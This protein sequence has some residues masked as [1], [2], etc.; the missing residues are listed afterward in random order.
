MS[1]S[2]TEKQIA[3]IRAKLAVTAG[4]S[5]ANRLVLGKLLARLL[6]MQGN[7][8][9]EPQAKAEPQDLPQNSPIDKL[10]DNS[11]T[12][13]E[14]SL[15][16]NELTEAENFPYND[17]QRQGIKWAVEGHSFV[18]TGA[19]GTG[20]TTNLRGIV[21]NL[22]ASG[23]CGVIG[24][25]DHKYIHTGAPGIV[26]VSYTNKA[27]GNIKRKLPKYLHN[28]CVTIHKL[29]E[30]QPVFEES[31]NKDTGAVSSTRLFQPARTAYNPLPRSIRILIVDES[32][33]LDVPLWNKLIAAL[34]HRTDPDLQIILMGDIQ[35]L[36]PVFGKSVFIHALQRG[37]P[38]TELTEVYRTALDNPILALAHR[39][40]SGKVIPAPE[41]PKWNIDKSA[42]GLG[43]LTIRPWKKKLTDL[44]AN[45]YL[46]GFI[47]KLIDA[48]HFNPAEDVFLTLFNVNIG[49]ILINKIIATHVAKV[50]NSPVYEIFTG[51][52]KVY[53]RVGE[54]VLYNKSDAIVLSIKPNFQYF[55]RTPRPASSTMDYDGMEHDKEKVN[56]YLNI[57]STDTEDFTGEDVHD[58][59]DRM[60]ESMGSPVED[61]SP[62]KRAASHVVTVRSVDTGEEH[63]LSS[64]GELNSLMLAYAIT[65]HKSLGSEYNRVFFLTHHTQAVMFQR[66]FLY[67]GVT[68]AKQELVVI[69]EP[70]F[71][72]Q[73]ITS[74]KLPGKT[75]EQK[76][77]AFE[78][79]LRLEQRRG[80]GNE[81]Q[82]PDELERF[83]VAETEAVHSEE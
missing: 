8:T 43:K 57:S 62:A 70:N 29:L 5:P 26:L 24:Q 25:T 6:K 76:I 21:A 36:P 67:V 49:T 1:D 65:V 13:P 74:Q 15:D 72:V 73:G 34:P 58:Y 31:T 75:I 77:E 30:Y 59:V 52:S 20:K 3:R 38:V 40:L 61:G 82:V 12:S 39:I 78:A 44:Q 53:L 7:D 60:M 55:G 50:T 27:V 2:N 22:I 16:A 9:T 32:T 83:L 35:Q 51:L 63:T 80:R 11:E 37:F 48:G 45:V 69:C 10:I 28:N 41:L 14:T 64:A 33:M 18:L 4:L 79:A 56:G 42:K 46:R 23:R 19:A 17:Q 71:F 47:P 68:R 66:E 81:D 54:R